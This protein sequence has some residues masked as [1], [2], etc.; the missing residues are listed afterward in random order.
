MSEVR[1]VPKEKVSIAGWDAARSCG[2]PPKSLHNP[3]DEEVK[4]KF[5]IKGLAE[6][7][8]D[9]TVEKRAIVH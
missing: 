4:I 2:S 7:R 3:G 5:G 9:Q 8:I 1:P 6:V